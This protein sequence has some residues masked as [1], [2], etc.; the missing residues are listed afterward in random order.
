MGK[1]I[2]SANSSPCKAHHSLVR[3]CG[4]GSPEGDDI[5]KKVTFAVIRANNNWAEVFK[6]VVVIDDGE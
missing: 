4:T 1:S 6:V 3:S 2:L 5:P